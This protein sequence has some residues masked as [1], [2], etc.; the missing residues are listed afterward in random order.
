MVMQTLRQNQKP[1]AKPKVKTIQRAKKEL[2]QRDKYEIMKALLEA[3]PEHKLRLMYKANMDFN[4][5]KIYL[6]IIL[7]E[8]LA[9]FI[10]ERYFV[11]KKGKEYLD[12]VN[13]LLRLQ[14]QE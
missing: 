8:G 11:S 13:E 9:D 6:P 3:M 5:T 12:T 10:H 4:R 14:G 2:P 1:K 7:K